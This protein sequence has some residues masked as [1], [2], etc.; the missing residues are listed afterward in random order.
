[1]RDEMRERTV[2]HFRNRPVGVS[3][4]DKAIEP[5]G[6]VIMPTS[7]VTILITPNQIGSK[8]NVLINGSRSA[9]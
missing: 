1:M 4:D 7:A 2:K 3:G 8:P 5:T 9:P 6:G